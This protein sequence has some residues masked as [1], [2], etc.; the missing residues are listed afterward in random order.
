[1]ILFSNYQKQSVQQCISSAIVYTLFLLLF[2][3]SIWADGSAVESKSR[4]F[5]NF[6]EIQSTL[7]SPENVINRR[8]I[9]DLQLSPDSKRIAEEDPTDPI[10][11]C[12]Q[13]YRGLRR[14]NVETEF[15]AYP[16]MGHGPREEKHHLDVLNRMI[17]WFEKYLKQ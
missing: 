5:K 14:Y 15:V 9:S 10:G 17:H 11:Q 12:Q 1:M 16:R 2:T 7:L 8:R 6:D 3:P 4:Y 13:F